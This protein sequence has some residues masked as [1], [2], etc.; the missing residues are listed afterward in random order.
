M[1]LQI[2]LRVSNNSPPG[3]VFKV[4]DNYGGKLAAKVL[5]SILDVIKKIVELS[6][7]IWI[8]CRFISENKQKLVSGSLIG[9]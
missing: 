9:S 5:L 2:C 4:A 3:G 8:Y 7:I 1:N 6:P